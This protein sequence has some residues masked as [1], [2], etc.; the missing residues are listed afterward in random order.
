M[1][2]ESP[3]QMSLSIQL[4]HVF[5]IRIDFHQRLS[6]EPMPGGSRTMFPCGAALTW[7]LQPGA[8]PGWWCWPRQKSARRA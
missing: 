7:R 1:S 3:K 2:V 6:F 4:V 8:M 5:D